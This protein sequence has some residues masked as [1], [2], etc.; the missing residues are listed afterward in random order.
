MLQAQGIVLREQGKQDNLE[1]I[2][3]IPSLKGVRFHIVA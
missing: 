3:E 2:K 1:N